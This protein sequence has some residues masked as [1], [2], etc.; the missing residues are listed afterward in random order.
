M[1]YL[2]SSL[3]VSVLTNEAPRDRLLAW[4]ADC[5]QGSLFISPW[6]STEVSSAF[7]IKQRVGSLTP[8]SR[9]AAKQG[10]DVF[11]KDSVNVLNIRDAH[12]KNA[13]LFADRVD[14]GLRSGDALHL[15][16]SQANGLTLATLDKQLAEAGPQ[17]GA[18]TL[19]L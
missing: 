11:I 7:S 10:Y 16:I 8:D 18:S 19:L 4:M 14:I 6:V 2:D 1:F 13:A 17:L 12:F 3:I 9:V 15:A 5:E